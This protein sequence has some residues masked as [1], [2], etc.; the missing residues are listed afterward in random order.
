M[1]L[2]EWAV[3]RCGGR[4]HLSST[5]I[6][7]VHQHAGAAATPWL[8]TWAAPTLAFPRPTH[9]RAKEAMREM[10]R[11][12]SDGSDSYLIGYMRLSYQRGGGLLCCGG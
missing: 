12:A 11:R 6:R 1:G 7:V 4:E 5:V 10:T 9:T 2:S 8:R 3:Q